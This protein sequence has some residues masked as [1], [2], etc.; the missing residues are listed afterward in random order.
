MKRIISIFLVLVLASTMVPTAL[1][2]EPQSCGNHATW[3]LKDGVL[4]ISGTGAVKFIY[5]NNPWWHNPDITELVIEEGITT[6]EDMCLSYIPNLQK[7]TFPDS[8][9]WIGSQVFQGC[10]KLEQITLPKNLKQIKC[11]ASSFT[12]NNLKAIYVHPDNTRYYSIDGVLMDR[13]ESA[14][15]CYPMGKTDPEFTI[16]QGI[17][18]IEYGAFWRAKAEQIYLPQGLTTIGQCAFAGANITSVQIPDTVTAV[19]SSAFEN[20]D[21]LQQVTLPQSVQTVRTYA[22]ASCMNLET[23]TILNPQCQITNQGNVLERNALLR[24]YWNSSLHVYA[25]R[26]GR[27]FQDVETGTVYSYDYGNAAYMEL[28]PQQTNSTYP[29]FVNARMEN[30]V[31]GEISG[32]QPSIMAE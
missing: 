32:Y 22:F 16:P 2:A 27:N 28:L 19:E 3:T 18:K 30:I 13:A 4:T 20:C 10:N 12:G 7:I 31:T 26:Y 15:S 14:V 21:R 23:L 29:S 11:A 6:L 5:P 9:Q 24:G 8:L 25:Q 17:R 1:A